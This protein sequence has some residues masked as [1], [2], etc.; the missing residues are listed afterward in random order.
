ME[1]KPRVGWESSGRKYGDQAFKLSAQDAPSKTL[2]RSRADGATSD[3]LLAVSAVFG[4]D[5]SIWLYDTLI[6]QLKQQGYYLTS[7]Y[8]ERLIRQ[9]ADRQVLSSKLK[10]EER[11]W[12]F[13][14]RTIT[15]VADEVIRRYQAMAA[16]ILAMRFITAGPIFYEDL[17]PTVCKVNNL[18]LRTLERMAQLNILVEQEV[19]YQ[20]AM[21]NEYAMQE[22]EVREILYE[23]LAA[24]RERINGFGN[25]ITGRTTALVLAEVDPQ[26][27]G[28]GWETIMRETAQSSVSMEAGPLPESIS[29]QMNGFLR[30]IEAVRLSHTRFHSS[31]ELLE[32][33]MQLVLSFRPDG[34]QA[35]LPQ[36]TQKLAQITLPSGQIM[37]NVKSIKRAALKE[38]RTMKLGPVRTMLLTGLDILDDTHGD[39]LDY[40]RERNA[41]GEQ[42]LQQRRKRLRR[43]GFAILANE[44]QARADRSF[45]RSQ[46]VPNVEADISDGDLARRIYALARGDAEDLGYLQQVWSMAEIQTWFAENRLEPVDESF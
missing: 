35:V 28:G 9:A 34:E 42:S 22:P 16:A 38:M 18:T 33:N 2:K 30:L 27:V 41:L 43:E 19:A 46:N 12:G 44:N 5:L 37:G 25:L 20:Q 31:R 7:L 24:Q 45:A 23:R 10:N 17:L 14:L 13:K 6:T 3:N 40:T 36:R 32:A 21:L 29:A 1:T 8:F 26:T 39:W 11:A 15:L 4:Q